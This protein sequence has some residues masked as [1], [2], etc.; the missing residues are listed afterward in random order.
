[1]MVYLVSV[2]SCLSQTSTEWKQRG[3]LIAQITTS[4]VKVANASLH[5]SSLAHD[6]FLLFF[7]FSIIV[8][9]FFYGSSYFLVVPQHRRKW[10]G[11]SERGF[12]LTS[13]SKHFLREVGRIFRSGRSGQFTQGCTYETAPQGPA[14]NQTYFRFLRLQED[15][16]AWPTWAL[17]PAHLFSFFLC[18]TNNPPQDRHS[19]SSN[20]SFC[21]RWPG[22]RFIAISQM[23]E[24][25]PA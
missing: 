23:G 13:N 9:A 11:D 10:I 20:F 8:F 2:N 22:S 19:P 14:V 12:F 4:C 25:R 1:M 24:F 17:D 6:F 7:F 21:M 18:K 15:G 16:W 5:G 3:S